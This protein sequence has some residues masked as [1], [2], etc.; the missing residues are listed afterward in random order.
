MCAMLD[1]VARPMMALF[2]IFALMCLVDAQSGGPTT[3]ELLPALMKRAASADI[4]AP[5]DVESIFPL[6][7]PQKEMAYFWE[8]IS[9]FQVLCLCK[10]ARK[11]SSNLDVVIPSL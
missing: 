1:A 9:L 3:G 2:A 8:R 5:A 11:V 10:I 4:P 7:R 6:T